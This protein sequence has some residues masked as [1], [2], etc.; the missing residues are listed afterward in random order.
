MKATNLCSVQTASAFFMAKLHNL[1][2]YM[3]S[4]TFN[5]KFKK[6][7]TEMQFPVGSCLS[8]LAQPLLSS[9]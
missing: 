9:C 7:I 5:S 8:Y 6:V 1:S 4:F 3:Q 2:L